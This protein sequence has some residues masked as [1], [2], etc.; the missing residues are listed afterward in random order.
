MSYMV[1]RT[2]LWDYLP[3][4]IQQK[5]IKMA[6]KQLHRERLDQVCCVCHT[7]DIGVPMT[8]CCGKPCHYECCPAPIH[9]HEGLRHV[10]MILDL[11]GY[12]VNQQFLIR[13]MGW[14]DLKG[15]TSSYHFTPALDYSQLDWKDRKTVN[16]VYHHIYGLRFNASPGEQALPDTL[17]I[18][19]LQTLYQSLRTSTQ[20]VVA[21]KGGSVEKRLLDKLNIPHVNLEFFGC[22]KVDVLIEQ[23]F[24]P[25][26][27]C[28]HHQK[29]TTHC[30]RQ[31]T[32]LFYQWLPEHA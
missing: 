29:I 8:P 27:S 19:M 3:P 9:L 31:E 23:G 7:D 11:D 13:E 15:Q 4:E 2:S 22:P 6:D 17:A 12:F 10:C 26:C 14:C 21:Y 32:F 20:Y 25:V 1:K 24:D 28:G 18:I 30:P 16:Y 5:I